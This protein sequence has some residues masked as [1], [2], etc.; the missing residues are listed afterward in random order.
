MEIVSYGYFYNR[1]YPFP[2]VDCASKY[3]MVGAR[4]RKSAEVID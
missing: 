2:L 4:E 1:L 3:P